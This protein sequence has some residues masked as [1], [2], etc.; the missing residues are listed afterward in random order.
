M[1]DKV[2]NSRPLEDALLA[3]AERAEAELNRLTNL[4]YVRCVESERERAERMVERLIVEGN[5][6]AEKLAI[7]RWED[8]QPLDWKDLVAEWQARN[9]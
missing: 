7:S 5:L 4:T 8:D 3:R 6:M 2:W 1:R 9:E